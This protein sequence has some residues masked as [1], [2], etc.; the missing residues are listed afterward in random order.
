[1]RARGGKNVIFLIANTAIRRKDSG[2]GK[3]QR[4]SGD[5][6]SYFAHIPHSERQS[7]ACSTGSECRVERVHNIHNNVVVTANS[8]GQSSYIEG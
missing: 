3:L 5:K 2:E 1:M 4:L 8:N 6:T 7:E